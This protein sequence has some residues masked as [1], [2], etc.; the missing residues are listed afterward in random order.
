MSG[1]P[2]H[3]GYRRVARRT[4]VTGGARS[5]KSSWAEGVLRREP[6][7]TYVA[8]AAAMPDDAEWQAR[9]AEHR[10]RRPA[11]WA[12][13]ETADVAR[14]LRDV[15]GA[16]LVD[17]VGNWLCRAL[18]DTGAWDDPAALAEVRDRVGD[19]VDAWSRS[20][21]RVVAVTNEVGDGVVPPTPSGRLFRDELGRLNAALAAASDTVVLMVCGI[22]HRLR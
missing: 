3:R 13:V 4:L 19:L 22:P 12:T 10:L 1:R 11:R 9:I 18:D 14:V 8:T 15:R 7:V 17:D 6:R 16:V 21:A 5:G 20:R 2:W